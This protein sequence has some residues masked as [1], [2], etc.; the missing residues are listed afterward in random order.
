MI[1]TRRLLEFF[2]QCVKT[3]S[4]SLME[5]RFTQ[6]LYQ[7]FLKKADEV[8]LDKKTSGANLLVRFNGNPAKKGIALCAHLD[9]VEDGIRVIDPILDG[10]LIWAK[11]DTILGADNKAAIAM[12]TEALES[13][14]EQELD[15]RPVDLVFTFGEEKHLAGARELDLSLL[16]FKDMILMDATGEVGGIIVSSPTHYTF[17]ITVSGKRAHAGI[18]PE[19]GDNAIQN[20]AEILK[21]L[22]QGR[23]DENTTFNTGTIRGGDA[24]NIIPDRVVIE[25]EFRSSSREKIAELVDL[26]VKLNFE[27]QKIQV[28]LTQDYKGYEI[29][30]HNPLADEVGKAMKKAGLSPRFLKS[31]GGSDANIFREKGIEALNLASGMTKPHSFEE[32][33]TLDSLIQGTEVILALLKQG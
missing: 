30:S 13:A 28:D 7:Y 8:I 18:E 19:K 17:K 5:G 27:T 32:C 11:D 31:G 26:M 14:R 6:F 4:P 1:Q 10:N 25:G 23:L 33:I 3:P 24:T 12:F 9:T 15:M 2:F 16:R 20:A 22:P 29:D 21:L